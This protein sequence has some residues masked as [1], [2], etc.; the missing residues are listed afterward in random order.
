TPLVAVITLT[1][2]IGPAR[3]FRLDS[4]LGLVKPGS[5]L[6]RDW[7]DWV[8]DPAP[9]CCRTVARGPLHAWLVPPPLGLLVQ[10]LAEHVRHL[11]GVP[12]LPP[13]VHAA[14]R[15]R[16]D[17]VN[18]AAHPAGLGDPH[19]ELVLRLDEE[20]PGQPLSQRLEA[21]LLGGVRGVQ[22]R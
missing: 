19:R 7:T 12:E 6:R 20:E 16:D 17:L 22:P 5:V 3:R 14:E 13:G 15:A 11:A 18:Q 2:V 21:R 4:F 8:C 1:C 10:Q 9:W